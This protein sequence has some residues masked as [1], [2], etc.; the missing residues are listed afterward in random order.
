MVMIFRLS[1]NVKHKFFNFTFSYLPLHFSN[2]IFLD[3]F[4][5]LVDILKLNISKNMQKIQIKLYSLSQAH[6]VKLSFCLFI[7]W[8][9][10]Q[11]KNHQT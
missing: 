2:A 8:S 6:E 7:P 10:K 9:L 11:E 1:I 3:F 4:S 5:H